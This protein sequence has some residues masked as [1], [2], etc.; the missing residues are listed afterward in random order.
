MFTVFSFF[1]WPLGKTSSLLG[2]CKVH[3]K[4]IASKNAFAVIG[5]K[6]GLLA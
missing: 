2:R 3:R 5:S 1:I 4:E 6:G